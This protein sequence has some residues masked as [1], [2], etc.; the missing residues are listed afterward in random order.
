MVITPSLRDYIDSKAG[1]RGQKSLK[2]ALDAWFAE[3][4]KANGKN[5]NDVKRSKTI[6]YCNRYA[7]AALAATTRPNRAMTQNNNTRRAKM[8]FC[9]Q[10]P[11]PLE[12]PHEA[13]LMLG[14]VQC[15]VIAKVPLPSVTGRVSPVVDSCFLKVPVPSD[16]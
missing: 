15:P 12:A 5:T 3:V 16:A 4:Q 9:E 6:I 11:Q 14:E 10:K 7:V 13:C 1:H 8:C 2:N